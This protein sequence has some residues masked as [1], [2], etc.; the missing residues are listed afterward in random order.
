[1][2][3]YDRWLEEPYMNHWFICK[4]CNNEVDEGGEDGLCP[5]CQELRAAPDE[6]SDGH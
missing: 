6:F 1:M 4:G 5:D 3:A 2:S